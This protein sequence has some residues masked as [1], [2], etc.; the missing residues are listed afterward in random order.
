[1]RRFVQKLKDKPKETR[2]KIAL[3][4]SLSATGLIFIIWLT[5]ITQGGLAT[6]GTAKGASQ[7]TASPVTA[8]QD[9]A[10]AAYQSIRSQVE[11]SST[12]TPTSSQ[13]LTADIEPGTTSAAETPSDGKDAAPID[14]GSYWKKNQQ[15]ETN[16]PQ[17]QAQP[18]NFW[19]NE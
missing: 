9:N 13:P 8:L 1:M 19:S 3:G 16:Q 4:T 5:V 2:H 6:G 14:S 12:S 18:E 11:P 10:A 15:E 7:Q 17:Q